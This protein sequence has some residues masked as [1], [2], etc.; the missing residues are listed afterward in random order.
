TVDGMS[1][2]RINAIIDL[3]RAERYRWTP[4]RRV[5]VPKPKGGTR[6][7]GL[8][9]WGDKL[10]QEVLRALLEPYYE[11]RFST[12]SHGFRPNRGCHSALQEIRRTWTGTV[13]FI[14]GDIKGCFDNIDRK[15]LLEI[16]RQDIHD[17]R[18]VQLIA[19]LLDAGYVEDWRLQDSLSGTPQGGIL[20]P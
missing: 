9:T 18:L 1:L 17:G 3:L 12:H 8:P 6:P 19:N 2:Q 7:L 14:E 11:Q 16:V 13:W 4:V 10:V 5:Q 20:S 15:T